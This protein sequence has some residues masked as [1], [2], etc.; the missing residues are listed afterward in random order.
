MRPAPPT[1]ATGCLLGS[2]A[3][4]RA[5]VGRFV[6]SILVCLGGRR[7]RVRIDE[8][9]LL[10]LVPEA[11]RLVLAHVRDDDEDAA[12]DGEIAGGERDPLLDEDRF[13]ERPVL[14][15]EED[16]DIEPESPVPALDEGLSEIEPPVA[17]EVSSHE[18]RMVVRIEVL[19]VLTGIGI[20]DVRVLRGPCPF[21]KTRDRLGDAAALGGGPARGV[22]PSSVG[23][24]SSSR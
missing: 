6:R 8:T 7:V 9:V 17:V 3:G 23:G 13:A 2:D 22:E 19:E 16:R 18:V 24:S 10:G 14:P 1:F 4:P 20:E 15:A 21:G 12:L 5:F 11:T